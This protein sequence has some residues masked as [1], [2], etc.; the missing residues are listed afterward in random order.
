MKRVLDRL[1]PDRR[2]APSPPPGR[3]EACALLEGEGRL[4][5]TIRRAASRS[6][7]CRLRLREVYARSEQRARRERADCFLRRGG[8]PPRPI[9]RPEGV[10][11]LLRR[12]HDRLEGLAREYETASAA[13][14][15]RREEYRRYAGECAR[16]AALVRSLV[17][18]AMG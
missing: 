16:D 4:Q 10:L 3:E 14:G 11:T 7:E 15:R 5:E 12:A 8:L 17:E 1:Y 2:G 18:R 6:R 9:P 13:N